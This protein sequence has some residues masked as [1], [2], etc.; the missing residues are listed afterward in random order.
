M[1]TTS[2]DEKRI[3]ELFKQA[4]MEFFEEQKDIFYD[5]VAEVIEDTALVN[6]I[7]EGESTDTVSKDEI[8]EILE[9]TT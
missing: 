7:K 1:A 9:G 3:K 5:L 6:A 8:L 2:L 4:M